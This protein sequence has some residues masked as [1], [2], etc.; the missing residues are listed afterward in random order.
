MPYFGEGLWGPLLSAATSAEALSTHRPAAEVG[1]KEVF[2]GVL[3]D[4]RA[5]T[6][7]GEVGRGW[8]LGLLDVVARRGGAREVLR[9]LLL[10]RVATRLGGGG[11]VV[12]KTKKCVACRSERGW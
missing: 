10:I 5:G 9:R 2:E 12:R 1:P 3:A 4:P 11:D 6:L 7:C 8:R